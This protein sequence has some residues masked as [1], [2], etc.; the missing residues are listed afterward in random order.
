MTAARLTLAA[1][2]ADTLLSYAL[3]VDPDPL[4]VSAAARLTLVVSNGSRAAITCQNIQVTLP[5]G[6]AAK[7]LI[8]GG[9]AIETQVPDGW[10]AAAAGGV[11]TLTP[12]GDAGTIEGQGI[13]FVIA[14]TTNGEPGTATVTIAETAS[15]QSQPS[16]TH[17][18]TIPVPKFPTKFRLSD[19]IVTDP[20]NDDVPAGGSATLMWTG[21]GDGVTYT[22]EY[23]PADDAGSLV[24]ETVGNVG[25]YTSKVP[26]T[27]SGSVTFTLTASLS[28][29][30][31]DHPLVVARQQTVTVET[32]SLHVVVEPP[33]VGV[34]G[35]VRLAWDAPNAT[36]CTLED[37]TEL[38]PLP[39]GR[40]YFTL[41][42]T[43][44]F[45][46]TAAGA[47]TQQQDQKTVMVDPNITP[48]SE[49]YTRSGVQG[50]PGDPGRVS[51]GESGFPRPTAG[52]PGR[53]GEDG[54]LRG[55]LPPLDSME[56]PARVIP[57]AIAGGRGGPGGPGGS[58]F[59]I[60]GQP[61]NQQ[62]DGPG[63]PGGNAVLDVTLDATNEPAAQYIVQIAPGPGGDPGDRAP[64]GPPGSISATIDGWP[65]IISS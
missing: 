61:F 22:M 43:R 53:R 32:L 9:A 64:A 65:L 21:Q 46:I 58:S 29:P 6:T 3:Y 5:A 48:N 45:T 56:A 59:T 52:G 40:C 15:S 57:I 24:S 10:S 31:Q 4:Q 11:V 41:K 12:S 51:Q 33:T 39:K 30:G 20:K 26:L 2:T 37:G 19:L 23:Q 42:Q 36:Q 16:A 28:I 47:G 13:S 7:D 34:N 44:R 63:G 14:T 25:P 55:P 27:R 35:L 60:A 62:P 38:R 1:T 50:G 8:P 54:I 17:T 18:A 49:G